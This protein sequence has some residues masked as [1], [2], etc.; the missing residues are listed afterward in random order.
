MVN[1]L[2]ATL[3]MCYREVV[4]ALKH[5]TI[6]CIGEFNDKHNQTLESNGEKWETFFSLLLRL[7]LFSLRYITLI[8]DIR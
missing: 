2:L 3:L 8:L 5:G 1:L 4:R 6:R 7:T